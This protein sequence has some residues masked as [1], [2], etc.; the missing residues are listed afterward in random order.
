MAD[1][2]TD[3]DRAVSPTEEEIGNWYAN[4]G[5]VPEI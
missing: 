4:F 1:G 2:A 5:R 3:G